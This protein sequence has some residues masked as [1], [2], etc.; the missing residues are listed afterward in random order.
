MWGY[1]WLMT[2]RL[3]ILPPLLSTQKW[4]NWIFVPKMCAILSFWDLL[5]VGGV[6]EA[7]GPATSQILGPPGTCFSLRVHLR[8]PLK[9]HSTIILKG[10]KENLLAPPLCRETLVSRTAN[11]RFYSLR[12]AWTLAERNPIGAKTRSVQ[13]SLGSC[14]LF[15]TLRNLPARVRIKV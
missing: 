5:R 4:Q 8:D 12:T 14:S 9:H 2:C 15:P 3:H 10:L 13:E 6:W 7:C 1:F 11:V